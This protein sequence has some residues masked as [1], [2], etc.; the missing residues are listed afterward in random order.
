MNIEDKIKRLK[1]LIKELRIDKVISFRISADSREVLAEDIETVLREL[2]NKD[3]FIKMSADVIKNSILIE[4][5]KE[6]IKELEEEIKKDKI[7]YDKEKDELFKLA[8]QRSMT[9]KIRTKKVL[10]ELL[11]EGEQR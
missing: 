2:G 5:I 10:E 6:K 9:E 4:K 11:E 1:N 7:E 8:I 3:K